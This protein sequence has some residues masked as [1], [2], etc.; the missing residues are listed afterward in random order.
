MSDH[1]EGMLPPG[2]NNNLGVLHLKKLIML[3]RMRISKY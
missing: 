1:S 2:I 3:M